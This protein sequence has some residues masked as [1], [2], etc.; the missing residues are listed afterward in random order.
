MEYKD[1]DVWKKS[2]ELAIIILQVAETLP[3]IENFALGFQIRKSA[4]SIPSNIAEGCGR[5]STKDT[6]QFLYIARG[7]LYEIETQIILCFEMNYIN[8]PKHNEILSQIT[9]CKKLLNGFI[10]YYFSKLEQHH[11]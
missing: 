10:N 6:L 4:I 5:N 9:E 3:Q 7:S 2:K 11:H 8:E 1:L